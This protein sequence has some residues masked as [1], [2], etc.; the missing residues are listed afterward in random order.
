MSFYS[1]DFQLQSNVTFVELLQS[2][3]TVR[4]VS[5]LELKIKLRYAVA[6]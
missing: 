2:S 1:F 6:F 5:N 3:E 4:L